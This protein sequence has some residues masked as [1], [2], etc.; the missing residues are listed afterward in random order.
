MDRSCEPPFFPS[1]QSSNQKRKRQKKRFWNFE[2]LKEKRKTEKESWVFLLKVG[3]LLDFFKLITSFIS[4]LPHCLSLSLVKAVSFCWVWMASGASKFIKCVTV[5]DGAVGKTCML[6]CYTSN[7]FPTV[8]HHF[9]EIDQ[10]VSSG[11]LT[12]SSISI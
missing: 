5:G 8:S 9:L 3:F 12:I 4:I 1:L 11:F 6:I 2:L 7:K 10:K